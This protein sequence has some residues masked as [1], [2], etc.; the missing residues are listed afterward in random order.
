MGILLLYFAKKKNSRPKFAPSFR[1][2][3]AGGQPAVC[4][5]LKVVAHQTDI[6]LD[7]QKTGGNVKLALMFSGKVVNR[8]IYAYNAPK[9]SHPKS[10]IGKQRSKKLQAASANSSSKIRQAEHMLLKTAMKPTK[11]SMGMKG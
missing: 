2:G 8:H 5:P 6:G 4:C 10:R 9:I 11:S 3:R 7:E 1:Q